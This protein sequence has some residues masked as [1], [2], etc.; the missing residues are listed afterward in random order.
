MD[1]VDELL[2]LRELL[3]ELLEMPQKIAD[4]GCQLAKNENKYRTTLAVKEWEL[5]ANGIPVTILGDLAR[6]DKQVAELKLLRD[7]SE[8]MYRTAIEKNNTIKK[9][10][11]TLRDIIKADYY[12]RESF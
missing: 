3:D 1:G 5:R 8:A 2:R 11:D 9:A 10:I 4:A 6:G 12:Q 7:S